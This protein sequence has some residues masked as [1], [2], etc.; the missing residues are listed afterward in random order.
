MTSTSCERAVV[1]WKRWGEKEWNGGGD[2][3]VL[4]K[5]GL[6]NESSISE[7]K[8]KKRKKKKNMVK[9]SDFGVECCSRIVGKYV[10]ILQWF[11]DS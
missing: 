2:S 11:Y 8:K 9:I 1:C 4:E 10:E 6:D 5:L 7:P 3:E